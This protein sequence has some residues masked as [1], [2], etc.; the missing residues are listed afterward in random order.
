M[1]LNAGDPAGD[2]DSTASIAGQLF[3]AKHGL[4]CLPADA[5]YRIDVLEALL[6]VA[7]EWSRRSGVTVQ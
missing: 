4:G 7:G 3:G 6:E 1:Q 5:V 2:S